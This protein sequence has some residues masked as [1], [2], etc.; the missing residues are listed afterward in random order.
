MAVSF[1]LFGTLVQAD[2]PGEPWDAVGEALSE[3][4]V[5]VPADWEATYRSAHVE[6][7]PLAA[8]SLVEHTQAA[9]A[10]Q[11]IDA[12]GDVVHD[13]LLAAFDGQVTVA[14][15]AERALSAARGTGPVGLLSNCSVPGLVE[16][17]LERASLSG[18]FDAVVTSLGCGW[19]KPHDRAFTHVSDAL[20]ADPDSLL[21][22]G[23]DSRAD[24]G[25]RTTGA[26]VVLTGQ[27]PLS[28]FPSVLEGWQ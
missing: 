28:E 26:T 2:R 9:L 17:T 18:R 21:H 5:S 1:D 3:R 23:D 16:R 25:G 27:T 19:R 24:G 11:G 15:G 10:S 12:D 22:V 7:A 20:G 13:A 6:T 14:D 8:Q 4:D